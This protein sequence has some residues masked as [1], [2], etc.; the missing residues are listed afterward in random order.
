MIITISGTPGSGKSTLAKFLAERLKAD[1]IY[2]GGIR[3][4]LARKKGMTLEELNKYA[5]T[6]PETD[7][8]VD[9]EAAQKALQL[10]KKGKIL[11][12]EG[13]TQYHFLPTSI[14]IYMKVAFEEGV[15]RIWQDLQNQE[16][17]QQRNEGKINSLDEL[18]TKLKERQNNDIRRYK[19]YYHLN[20]YDE[21]QYDIVIDTTFNTMEE[22]RKQVLA[23]L[24]PFLKEKYL[25]RY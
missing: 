25:N 19:K 3:R 14:K 2:V 13:R 15:K 22:T 7:V 21:K 9:K 18:Q 1:Y 17:R 5:L 6:H 10:E 12:V 8:D 16:I 4:E 20:P 23:R 11:I 24:Q